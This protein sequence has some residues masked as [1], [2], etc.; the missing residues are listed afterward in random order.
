MA[1]LKR[2]ALQ[3]SLIIFTLLYTLPLYA[4]TEQPTN[5]ENTY[6]HVARNQLTIAFEEYNKG[7][8]PESRKSLKK[9]S[10]WLYKAVN[11]SKSDK[12]K[13]ESK[14]LATEIDSFLLTLNKTPE[15]NNLGQF[16]HQASSLIKRE[17]EHLFH[18]YTES[19]NN[20]RT[21]K[22]LLDAKMHF[23]RADHDIFVSHD[24]SDAKLE[25]ESALEYLDEA[26]AIARA[27]IKP[28]VNKLAQ[29]VNNLILLTESNQNNWKQ[30]NLVIS[31][32][33]SVKNLNNAKKI[34]TPADK[35]RLNLI[36]DNIDQI[37]LGIQKN[38]IKIKYN[39][40]LLD[41]TVTINSI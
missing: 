15:E 5:S 29:K 2:K 11:H 28:L 4:Q 13:L 14:K 38:N 32:D 39:S 20:N 41:F 36:I 16:L 40:I 18:S 25:L 9:A 30:N 31:L 35:L 10:E 34:A 6:L 26:S 3:F 27:D 8:I 23:Y 7:N 24:S 19:S 21:L 12:V 37:K 33:R 1:I 17:S 22:H